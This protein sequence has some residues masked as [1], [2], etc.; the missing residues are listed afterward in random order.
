MQFLLLLL[1]WGAQVQRQKMENQAVGEY[2][3][4]M[5]DVLL[6]NDTWSKNPIIKS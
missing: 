3:G 4:E 6:Q 2:A 5:M 1:Q